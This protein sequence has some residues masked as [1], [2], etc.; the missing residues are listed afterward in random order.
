M[1]D[2]KQQKG[3]STLIDYKYFTAD[4]GEQIA[5]VVIG[6]GKPLIYFHGMGSTIE[7]QMP[8]LDMP[9]VRWSNITIWN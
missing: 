2:K 8:L 3:V 6:E 9:K 1:K 7:S 4:D 5:Y